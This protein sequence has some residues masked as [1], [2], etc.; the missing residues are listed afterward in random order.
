MCMLTT[1]DESFKNNGGIGAYLVPNKLSPYSPSRTWWGRLAFDNFY[2]VVLMIIM[3]NILFG[4]ILDTF[5]DLRE[6]KKAKDADMTGLCFICNL[7][8][9][10]RIPLVLLDASRCF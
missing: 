4:I 6:V 1:F 8:R 9:A 2:N 5:G 7:V 10:R 3:L